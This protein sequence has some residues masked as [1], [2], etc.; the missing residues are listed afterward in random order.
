MLRSAHDRRPA[1][2]EARCTPPRPRLQD[3]P[4]R[5]FVDALHPRTGAPKRF[6]LIECVDWVNVIALTPDRPGRADPPVPARHRSRSASRSPAA[7]STRART[8]LDGRRARAR[9]GDRLH[10]E[11]LAALGRVAPNP[12]I[13]NNCLHSFLAL[14]A[15]PTTAQRARRQRGD[16]GRDACRCAEVHA[17]L[18]DGAIDHALVDRRRSRTSRSSARRCVRRRLTER[19]STALEWRA[20]RVP[21]RMPPPCRPRPPAPSP[22]TQFLEKAEPLKIVDQRPGDARRGEA[23]L[24]RQLR[25]VHE[26]QDRG[27]ASTARPSRCRSA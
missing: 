18:R 14:D 13:Q 7:W 23:V 15:E 12:A 22:L 4:R 27:H 17:M 8:P 10:R 19:C 3:L 26:R 5:P 2:V 11:A 25:L 20:T 6:S 24:D 21:V 9:R 1:A 16:R